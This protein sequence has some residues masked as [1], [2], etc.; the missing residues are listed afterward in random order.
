VVGRWHDDV[1]YLEGLIVRSISHC[2]LLIQIKG[3]VDCL[4]GHV[5]QHS[6]DG[7]SKSVADP[8]SQQ[9]TQLQDGNAGEDLKEDLVGQI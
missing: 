2:S 3:L 6:A 8:L 7:S 4:T 1:P 9:P 5:Q